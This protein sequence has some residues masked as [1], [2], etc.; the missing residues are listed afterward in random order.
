MFKRWLL[1]IRWVGL[2]RLIAHDLAR[3][4]I[5]VDLRG[6]E[7]LLAKGERAFQRGDRRR[8][9]QAW[10]AAAI[11]APYDERVWLALLRVLETDADRLVCLRNLVAINP[12]NADARRLL[13]A[14]ETRTDH[15][16]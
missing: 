8:A 13:S 12:L 6:T 10:R 11:V 2:A 16:G 5:P 4:R 3:P 15:D 1:S 9:H 7:A 14:Y